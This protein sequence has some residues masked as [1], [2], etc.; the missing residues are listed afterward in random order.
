MQ[1]SYILDWV[2]LQK[3]VNHEFR[4]KYLTPLENDNCSTI[5]D[6]NNCAAACEWYENSKKKYS[7][8]SKSR[9]KQFL[10][11]NP[12]IITTPNGRYKIIKSMQIYVFKLGVQ[13]IVYKIFKSED[14]QNMFVLFKPGSQSIRRILYKRD[15]PTDQPT[16][17]DIDLYTS[18]IEP[19]FKEITGLMLE[20]QSTVKKFIIGGHSMGC[21]IAL[22]FA[23]F[24]LDTPETMTFFNDRVFVIGS[25]GEASLLKEY[26]LALKANPNIFIFY[27]S[28]EN[29]IDC[30]AN[31]SGPNSVKSD[32]NENKFGDLDYHYLYSPFYILGK[33]SI[34]KLTPPDNYTE[35]KSTSFENGDLPN[36]SEINPLATS[37]YSF[38]NNNCAGLHDFNFYK[39]LFLSNKD[40]ILEMFPTLVYSIDQPVEEGIRPAVESL[41]GKRTYRNRKKIRKIKSR[42]NIRCSKRKWKRNKK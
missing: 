2:Y 20:N 30:Y 13:F 37:T 5:T 32:R 18:F 6:G 19:L 9:V 42:K 8:V 26:F 22:R 12:D 16:T 41:G 25:G 17:K 36:A 40:K 28:T 27:S 11:T 38:Y 29:K 24:L 7:C 3:I 21:M 23:S 4:K 14:N 39:E 15:Q 35:Q 10:D 34:E 31:S 1:K 33:S